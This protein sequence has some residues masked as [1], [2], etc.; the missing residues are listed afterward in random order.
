MASHNEGPL[1]LTASQS[2]LLLLLFWCSF[3]DSSQTLGSDLY[4]AWAVSFPSLC[5]LLLT[6]TGIVSSVLWRLSFLFLMCLFFSQ[7]NPGITLSLFSLDSSP[8]F[9]PHLKLEIDTHK[10]QRWHFCIT[11]PQRLIAFFSEESMVWWRGIGF[12]CPWGLLP[13]HLPWTH[14][15]TFTE[16]ENFIWKTA[17]IHIS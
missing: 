2:M 16:S 9:S 13:F 15:P 8:S 11:S 10:P 4:S 6:D 12:R 14:F 7:V 17:T 1:I 3:F 5:M